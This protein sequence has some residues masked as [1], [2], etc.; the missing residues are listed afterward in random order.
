MNTHFPE[1]G[2]PFGLEKANFHGSNY[3]AEAP[4]IAGAEV[5]G[6]LKREILNTIFGTTPEPYFAAQ[7][8]LMMELA[9]EW[10]G[11]DEAIWQEMPDQRQAIVVDDGA[12]APGAVLTA[13]TAAVPG[14][15]GTVN[16]PV[17]AASYA[18]AKINARLHFPTGW[19]TIVSKTGGNT[20]V[21][22][23]LT[24]LPIP[25]IVQGQVIPMGAEIRSDSERQIFNHF[26][27]QGIE[28]FNYITTIAAAREYGRKEWL[29]IQNL[30]Q[31]NRLSEEWNALIY[32]FKW[33][34]IVEMWNGNRA[35]QLNSSGKVAKGTDGIKTQM[36]AGGV[37]PIATPLGAMIAAHEAASHSTNYRT[38]GVTYNIA[39]T[40][41][42]YEL[43]KAYKEQQVRYAPNDMV[44]NLNLD[45]IKIGSRTHVLVPCDAMADP[46]YFPG[47]EGHLFMID[48]AAV[49]MAGMRGMPVL[50]INGAMQR[51]LLK[52]T[53]AKGSRDD[54]QTNPL[55]ATF[56]PM[57]INPLSTQLLLVS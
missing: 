50:D 23:S 27:A 46:N 20:L 7:K 8:L 14:G 35:S 45:A 17:G 30:E 36:L 13:A 48:K 25:A 39:P 28:R 54:L 37:T 43:S 34:M 12:S 52:F 49:K 53:D 2:R 3:M 5:I 41:L 38:S 32:Q 56:A 24:S 51:E 57:L 22:N 42:L 44:A 26:R 1:G 6:S 33:D 47:W 31:T 11:G 18:A 10:F 19:A 9:Y 4:T 15:F 21:L 55:E 40:E 16:M 29:K